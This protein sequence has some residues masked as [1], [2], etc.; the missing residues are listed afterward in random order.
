V[1]NNDALTPY[2]L[3]P[4][5]W[6]I[7]FL[8]ITIMRFIPSFSALFSLRVLLFLLFISVNGFAQEPTFA[9]KLGYPKNAKVIIFHVDD[10]GMSYDANDGTIQAMEKGVANSTSVM[11]PCAWSPAYMK[12]LQK[13]PKIDA[14]VHL[15]LTS[16][17]KNYRWE[18]LLG[19]LKVPG[20]HDAEGAF[21]SSVE[22]VATHAKPDEVEA[23]IREQIAR[24]RAFGLEP[25]HIDSHMGT[26]FVPMYMERYI[27]VGI[28][29]KIPVMFPGGH[30]TMISEIRKS[31]M[32]E[33]TQVKAIGQMLWNAGLPVLDDLFPDTYGWNLPKGTA[34]TDANLQK[35]KTQK[36]K[37]LLKALKPGV[38]MVI[39]HCANPSETFQHIT[40]SGPTRKGD[41]LAMLDPDLKQFLKDEKIIMTTWRELKERRVALK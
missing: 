3:V 33:R 25:T 32:P 27:K 4:Y 16:E 11:M 13:N 24:F 18:P 12:Y 31:A 21:W 37:E 35:M 15:T 6:L 29:E 10:A 1:S 23:E 17:W 14:G 8:F 20:L 38:T 7:N 19:R 34:I 26:L 2:Q 41:L 5:L 40:D 36:Y 9:E 22:Q 39:M 30:A 28:E